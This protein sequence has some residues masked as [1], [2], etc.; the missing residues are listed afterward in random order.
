MTGDVEVTLQILTAAGL[1]AAIGLER[2]LSAQQAGLRTHMLV[3]LGAAL[4]TLVGLDTLHTD[5]T[6]IAAQVVTGVGFLG[7]GAILRYGATVRGLTT[8]ASLWM[9][10][11]IGV[12]IGLH[13]WFA[14]VLATAIALIVLILLKWVEHDLLPGRRM[15]DVTLTLSSGVGVDDVVSRAGQILPRSRVQQVSYEGTSQKVLLLAQPD[16][17]HS[18]AEIAETLLALTGVEGVDISR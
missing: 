2:E 5:P 13:K 14:G 17:S 1:G 7:G 6:R 4:F 11:A 12:A 3:S 9:T 8:A 18:I 16:A 10:A 15:L